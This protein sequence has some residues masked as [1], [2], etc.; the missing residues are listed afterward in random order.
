M[1]YGRLEKSAVVHMLWRN[2]YSVRLA[3]EF[4]ETDIRF[5]FSM[6]KN[7]RINYFSLLVPRSHRES[8]KNV[9]KVRSRSPDGAYARVTA[10]E[11][12]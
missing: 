2:P 6:S 11:I 12:H 9:K 1:D 3:Q 10:G 4:S 8:V 5:G 7:P